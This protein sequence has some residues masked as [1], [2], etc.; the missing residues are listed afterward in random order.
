MM[1]IIIIRIKGLTV[2]HH[3]LHQLHQPFCE[4]SEGKSPQL[5]Q[6]QGVRLWIG[7][8]MKVAGGFHLKP[9]V[10]KFGASVNLFWSTYQTSHMIEYHFRAK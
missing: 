4:T 2:Q 3:C 9:A 10:E 6:A 7:K 1:M 5:I 8:G